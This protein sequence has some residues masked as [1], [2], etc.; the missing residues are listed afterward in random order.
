MRESVEIQDSDFEEAQAPLTEEAPVTIIVNERSLATL[1]CTPRD[2][3]DLTVGWLYAEG[4]IGGMG[5]VQH[6][7]GCRHDREMM[8]TVPEERLDEHDKRW[9]LVT[10]GCGAWANLEALRP[11]RPTGLADSLRLGRARLRDLFVEMLKGSRLYRTTG[12][13]HS[14]ALATEAGIVV[15][16]ED[17]GRHNAVDKV[18]GSALLNRLILTDLVLLATGRL[19]SEMAWKA[20]RAGVPIAASLSVPSVMARDIAEAAGVTLVGRAMSARPW[21]YTYPE[22]LLDD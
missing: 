14:A 17:I 9:R 5:D 13:V 8:V 11:T 12:G 10:S 1:M 2:L 22:R 7:V 21:V 3:K 19:S 20:A 18:I 4:I 15:Q 16:R 6:L